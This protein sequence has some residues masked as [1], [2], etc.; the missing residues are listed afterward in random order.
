MNVFLKFDSI[1]ERLEDNF[2]L[3]ANVGLVS[4]NTATRQEL[5]GGIELEVDETAESLTIAEQSPGTQQVTQIIDK[6]VENCVSLN[7]DFEDIFVITE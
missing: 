5:L 3:S 2:A 7:I 1:A 4:P 6:S